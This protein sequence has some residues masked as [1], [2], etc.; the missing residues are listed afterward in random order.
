MKNLLA[1]VVLGVCFS[2]QGIIENTETEVDPEK[3]LVIPQFEN[4]DEFTTVSYADS[5]RSGY[6]HETK[7]N[8][9][10][11]SAKDILLITAYINPAKAL[12][13]DA[14]KEL[15]TQLENSKIQVLNLNEFEAVKYTIYQNGK[16]IES[17]Q[18]DIAE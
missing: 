9:F 13:D 6:G 3:V 16:E 10:G 17:Y 11:N 5:L 14:I 15:K 12:D 4:G 18:K 1:G 7:S 8:L 2:C